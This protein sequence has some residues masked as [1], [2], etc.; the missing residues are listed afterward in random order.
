MA[1]AWKQVITEQDSTDWKNS[2]VKIQDLGGDGSTTTT[3]LNSAGSFSTPSTGANTTYSVAVKNG[4]TKINLVG[5]DATSDTI[6]FVGG[7]NVTVTR[8]DAD[9][10]TLSSTN[11][12]YVE[13]TGSVMGLMSTAHHD[14]L[15]GI[16]TSANN[17]TLPTASAVGKGG[18]QLGFAESGKD[19]PLEINGSG[20]AYVNIPWSNTTYSEATTS[21]EGLMSTAHHDKLDGIE[22]SATAD[23]TA[24]EIIGALNSDLGGNFTIGNQTTDTCTFTGGVTVTGGLTVNGTTTTL[25]TATIEVEDK[26]IVVAKNA[27]PTVTTGDDSGLEVMTSTTATDNPKLT[28]RKSEDLTGWCLEDTSSA[29]QLPIATMKFHASTSPTT[30]TAHGIGSFYFEKDAKSLYIRVS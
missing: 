12:T 25:N 5:S 19:Y 22:A 4:T 29:E 21:A 18:I 14:K 17:Y 24:V 27:S 28:W 7:T 30:E 1:V 15:D 10:L 8:T 26:S 3:Y 9:T 23:Q 16:A 11:T 13:A 2:N 20:Q 6:E